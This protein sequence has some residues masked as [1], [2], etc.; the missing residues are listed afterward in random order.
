[1]GF[2]FFQGDFMKRVLI[3]LAGFAFVAAMAAP[4]MRA[5]DEKTI[6][7]AVVDVACNKD[8]KSGADHDACAV[9]CAKRG[10]PAGI[11]AKDGVYVITGMYAA[12]KNAKLIEFVNKKIVAKGTVTEK[13]GQK[14]IDVTSITIAK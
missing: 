11:A 3:G 13:D 4:V 1:M 10:Q 8:G 14:M 9:S 7:G 12:D 6:T 5:A 2:P